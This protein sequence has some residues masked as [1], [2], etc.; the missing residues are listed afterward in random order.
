[1]VVT[2]FRLVVADPPW[3]FG[4]SLPG[5]TRGA[6]KQYRTMSYQ[7]I[8][9]YNIPGLGSVNSVADEDS[10]LLLWRVSSMLEDALAVCRG[11]GFRPHSELVWVKTRSPK[12]PIDSEYDLAFGMG[13]IVRGAHETCLIGLR[14][15]AAISVTNR[16]IRSVFFAPRGPHSAK[17]DKFYSIAESMTPGPRIELFARRARPRWSQ[18]GDELE[19]AA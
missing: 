4:D 8:V 16:S 9:E 19:G 1:L 2:K 10:I 13:R 17:P 15:S 18:V 12:K 5:K 7:E 3:S 14:G 11:W 6:A